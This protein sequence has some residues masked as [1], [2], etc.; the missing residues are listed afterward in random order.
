[1][2]TNTGELAGEEISEL[3]IGFNNSQVDRPVKLL[4]G[5]TKTYLAPQE[6]KKIYFT[7]PVSTLAWY[8]PEAKSWE[9]ENMKYEIFTGGSSVTK[10]LLASSFTVSE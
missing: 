8:N 5:F 10:N 7:V 1:M 3:Y 4:R 6:S 9:I 2:V